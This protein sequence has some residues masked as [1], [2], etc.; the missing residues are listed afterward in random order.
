MVWLVDIFALFNKKLDSILTLCQGIPAIRAQQKEDHALLEANNALLKEN[1]ELL[2]KIIQGP[3]PGLPAGFTAVLTV[4]N[5]KLEG[6]PM[7]PSKKASAVAP[8]L[9]V[10]DDGTVSLNIPFTDEDG[11]PITTLT[12]WP[13]G[14][15]FPTAAFSD[16]TPGPS[17][18]AYTPAA[19]PAPS[20]AVPG[21]FVAGSIA[22]VTPPSP[23]PPGWG[24][25][26]D[27]QISIAS[28]LVGQTSPITE[29]A[30]TLSVVADA[31]K[32]SGFAPVLSE[33]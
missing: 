6:E 10:N 4:D 28:G 22:P 33:P 32:P 25:N 30:G 23:L 12:A 20:T 8:S 11:L 14:V 2:H 16:A 9:T 26:V 31:S 24:Q 19:T 15:A 21:A 7:S 5:V 13:V 18:Y 27:V 1:N 17:A 29:D 3:Q